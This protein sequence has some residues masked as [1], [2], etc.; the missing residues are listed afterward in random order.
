MAVTARRTLRR[1]TAELAIAA[2]VVAAAVVA[3]P[4]VVQGRAGRAPVRPSRTRQL[5]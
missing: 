2:A 3:G 5:R 1:G 4:S